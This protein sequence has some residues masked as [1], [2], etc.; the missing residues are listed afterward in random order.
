MRIT[1]VQMHS[2]DNKTENLQFAEQSISQAATQEKPTIVALPEMFTFRG[3]TIEMRRKAAEALPTP[4]NKGGEAYNLLSE[5]AKKFKIVIHGGSLIERDGDKFYNTTVVFNRDG[6]ELARYRKIHLFNA[7]TPS[8]TQY[9]ESEFY[10]AGKDVVTYQV[11]GITIGCS[12]CFDLRFPDLYHALLKKGA[13]V[14]M[15]PSAFTGETG[16]AHWEILCRA[17]AIETQTYLV[18]PAITGTYKRDGEIRYTHGHSM[19]VDPWGKILVEIPEQVGFT[20]TELNLE[21]L[22][23]I[24][25]RMT[26]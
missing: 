15:V 6:S 18:A 10:S 7:V 12:I 26:M 19:I 1:I 16:A 20:S 23:V 25:A 4:G 9:Q 22:K 13:Q 14:I 2:Q 24:R 5:L 11:D 17:R 21:Y 8:G 3:G